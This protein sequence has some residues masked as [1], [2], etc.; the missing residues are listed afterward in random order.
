[1]A[2]FIQ[3]PKLFPHLQEEGGGQGAIPRYADF[4]LPSEGLNV[5]IC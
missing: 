5:L 2:K 3:V 1:M 4:P